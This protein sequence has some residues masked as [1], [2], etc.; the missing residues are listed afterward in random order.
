LR[1]GPDRWRWRIGVKATA[2]GRLALPRLVE[3]DANDFAKGRAVFPAVAMKAGVDS[4]A[5]VHP[6]ARQALKIDGSPFDATVEIGAP[7]IAKAR[8]LLRHDE[9]VGSQFGVR[10]RFL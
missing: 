8:R 1:G 6:D 9:R 10:M 3:V 2:L 7:R 4:S 5:R